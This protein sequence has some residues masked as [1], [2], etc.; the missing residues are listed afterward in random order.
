[1]RIAIQGTRLEITAAL[2]E[3]AERKFG[4]LARFLKRFEANGEQTVFIELA[5][6]T[7]H[8]KRGD[9]YYAEA[10]LA[11]PGATLRAECEADDVRVAIDRVRDTLKSAITAYKGVRD[12]RTKQKSSRRQK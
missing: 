3:Y 9:V 5:R 11:V 12:S 6:A 10:V 1:M 2:R 7:R 8:H 4:S